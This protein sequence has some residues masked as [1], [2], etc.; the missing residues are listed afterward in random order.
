MA[1]TEASLKEA[2]TSIEGTTGVALVDYTSGM[3]LGTLGGSKDFNL[4]VAAAGNTDVIRA[5]LRTMEHLGLKEEIEDILITLG[6]QYHLIRLLKTR[7]SN[8]LFLYLVLDA[9]RANL[10]MARHQLKKIESELEV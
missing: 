7:G 9:S 5:K 6:S 2:M 3:A 8:G 10:A 1:N 4:E